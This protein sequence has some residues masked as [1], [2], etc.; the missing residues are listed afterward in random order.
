LKYEFSN[1]EDDDTVIGKF[2]LWRHHELVGSG[3]Y[4]ARDWRVGSQT[5][6]G[7]LYP[8]YDYPGYLNAK[9]TR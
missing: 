8:G 9:K 4:S 2:N 1:T 5:R 3:Q 7:H 6:G